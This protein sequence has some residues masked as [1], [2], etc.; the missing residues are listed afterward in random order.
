[1][2]EWMIDWASERAS[3]R[4]ISIGRC[5]EN[6]ARC[7]WAA[8]LPFGE[9]SAR[10]P[11]TFIA[12][13]GEKAA[14]Y[15]ARVFPCSPIRI[16]CLYRQ[17][18]TQSATIVQIGASTLVPQSWQWC[19]LSCQPDALSA[20]TFS[21]NAAF[22]WVSSRAMDPSELSVIFFLRATTLHTQVRF[23]WLCCHWTHRIASRHFTT[24][25]ITSH[26][27]HRWS[28]LSAAKAKQT[29]KQINKQ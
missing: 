7:P 22:Y 8:R 11:I 4:V 3:E 10:S 19:E 20:S 6:L 28:S 9:R 2:N 23:V 1:M 26:Q 18:D 5:L 16:V 14:C 29:N 21:F 17:N 24:L 12:R 27:S 13:A 15:S 25:H